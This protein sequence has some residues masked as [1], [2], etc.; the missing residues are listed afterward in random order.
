MVVQLLRTSYR[1][2]LQDSSFSIDQYSTY[3]FTLMPS[4]QKRDLVLKIST[5]EMALHDP[6]GTT[7]N[8]PSI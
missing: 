5:E 2:S 4:D 7:Q 3:S 8:Q 1:T 6:T